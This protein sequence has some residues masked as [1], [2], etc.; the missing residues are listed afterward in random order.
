[1][2]G[3]VTAIHADLDST[4]YGECGDVPRETL[5]IIEHRGTR[6]YDEVTTSKIC[7]P[8]GTTMETA[9]RQLSVAMTREVLELHRG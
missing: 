2:A 9:D 1:M 8:N 6:P 7:H 5:H 3:L 4:Y